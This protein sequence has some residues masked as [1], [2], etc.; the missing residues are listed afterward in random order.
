MR[1]TRLSIAKT[2]I[3]KALDSQESRV[4]TRSMIEMLLSDNR[5]F[6]RLAQDTNVNDFL[7]YLINNTQLKLLKLDF[8]NRTEHRFTW[9]DVSIYT[10]LMSLRG[11][12]YFSHYTAVYFHNLTE[13]IPK[14]IYVNSEQQQGSQEKELQQDRIDFAF[15]KLGRTSRNYII[16]NDT[17]I[18]NI[19]GMNT[20]QLGIEE[21]GGPNGEIIRLTNVE[22][23]LIDITVRP[24]YAGD[25]YE[26]LKAFKIARE[27]DKVSV[28]KLSAMLSKLKFT[29]PY[30]QAIGF[31]MERSGVYD[32]NSLD[33]MRK[34]K[35]NF[36][37][38]LTYGMKERD[39]S[40][41]WRLFIPKGF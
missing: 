7:R 16:Y 4:F 20:G 29:Y 39:Y 24:Q 9:G 3:I 17:K 6:W 38:Y 33:V 26:V 18:Y 34:F 32:H 31:Y 19:A 40:K 36:D 14:T 5:T 21:G 10:V 12:P 15:R 2:D 25:V 8:P 41:D 37:F 30:H 22:R 23:T 28:N 27:S 35:M 13:Q 1:P 11:D